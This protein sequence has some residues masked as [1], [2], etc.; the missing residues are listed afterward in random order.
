MPPPLPAA[1]EAEASFWSSGSSTALA[2][3]ATAPARFTT[4]DGRVEA[5]IRGHLIVARA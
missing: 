3:Q 5:P 2:A 1:R 4:A